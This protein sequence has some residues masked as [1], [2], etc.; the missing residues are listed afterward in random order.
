MIGG[1]EEIDS[2]GVG[3]KNV[4][5]DRDG[6]TITPPAE[7][8]PQFG[9]QRS[10]VLAAA[11]QQKL[12]D[13]TRRVADVGSQQWISLARK[14]SDIEDTLEPAGV[15]IDDRLAVAAQAAQL[16]DEMLVAVDS[17]SP[18]Q[19]VAGGDRVS[20]GGLF[21]KESAVQRFPD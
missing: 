11:F 19:L 17:D 10:F 7:F 6:R 14:A 15:R 9:E 12:L 5:T 8:A 18:T 2:S 1:V 13:L 21:A 16:P 3:Q 20:T 4:A